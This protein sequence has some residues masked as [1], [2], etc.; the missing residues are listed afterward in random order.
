MCA[1]RATRVKSK[2]L[3]TAVSGVTIGVVTGEGGPAEAGHSARKVRGASFLL[4]IG[5]HTA[6]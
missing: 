6:G 5:V 4:L 3:R 2:S 1:T